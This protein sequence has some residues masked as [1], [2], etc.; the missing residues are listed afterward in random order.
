M[1][2]PFIVGSEISSCALGACEVGKG[3]FYGAKKIAQCSS[4][5]F[6]KAAGSL[7][8]ES[9][10]FAKQESS[11][12]TKYTKQTVRCQHTTNTRTMRRQSY[13]T[14]TP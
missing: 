3:V 14:L 9:S 1:Q 13:T 8:K 10:A 6:E 7:G 4:W 5:Q 11:L 2:S 12:F